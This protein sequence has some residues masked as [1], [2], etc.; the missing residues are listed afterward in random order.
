LHCDWR[1]AGPDSP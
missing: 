1:L